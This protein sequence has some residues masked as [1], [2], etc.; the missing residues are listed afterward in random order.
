[1]ETLG[2]RTYCI[3]QASS[4]DWSVWT[5]IEEQTYPAPWTKRE[6]LEHRH[7][8]SFFVFVLREEWIEETGE[9]DYAVHTPVRGILAFTESQHSLNVS[10]LAVHPE[11]QGAG[12][13]IALLRELKRRLEY[14]NQIVIDVPERNLH[15]QVFLRNRGFI[16]TT[17]VND[18][19]RFVSHKF[20]GVNRLEGYF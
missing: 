15:S 9:N 8:P 13:G 3:S 1:M 5:H 19:Y 2:G 6:W 20:H 4:T 7:D 11:Y 17:I 10:R 16:C 14:K 12:F 18:S